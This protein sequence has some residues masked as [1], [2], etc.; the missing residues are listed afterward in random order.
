MEMKKERQHISEHPRP[1]CRDHRLLRLCRKSISANTERPPLFTTPWDCPH[2]QS[3]SSGADYVTLQEYLTSKFSVFF[4]F[5]NP[6]KSN[7][8]LF[9]KMY[10]GRREKKG[11][12]NNPL[13]VIGQSW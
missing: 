8:F 13:L 12:L 3:I 11:H 9:P 2:G 1:F 6:A 4:F 10:K 7:K 5:S